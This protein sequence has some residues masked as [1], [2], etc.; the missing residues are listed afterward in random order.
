M[1]T[2]AALIVILSNQGY[3]FGGQPGTIRVSWAM[4]G[5]VPEAV[6]AWELKVDEVPLG[7]GL[8]RMGPGDPASELTV[9]VPEVR[10]RTP[11]RW[12]YRVQASEDGTLLCEGEEVIHIYPGSLLAGLNRLWK[13]KRVLV[14]DSPDGLGSVLSEA[15]IACRRIAKGPDLQTVAGEL[16][17]V[18]PDQLGNDAFAQASLDG[19]ARSG[20]GVLVFAQTKVDTL[21]GFAVAR[22][23]GTASLEWRAGHPLLKGFDTKSLQTLTGAGR[24]LWAIQLP[25]DAPV[26]EIGFWPREISGDR[27]VPIDALLSVQTVGAGRIVLCQIPLGPWERDPRSQMVL[28]NALRYLATRP[29]PTLPPSQRRP[30]RPPRSESRPTITIPPGGRS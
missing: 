18:G 20:A 6:L 27:P 26:L 30:R 5:P 22:R 4:K 28:A 9:T 29:E 25:A 19:L 1:K 21:F 15:G 14:W 8:I 16:I 2:A 11:M 7:S 17:V 10:V 23:A 13:G 12:H 24:Q 3:W